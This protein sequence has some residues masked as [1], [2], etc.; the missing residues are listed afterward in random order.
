LCYDVLADTVNQAFWVSCD[1]GLFQWKI[2]DDSFQLISENISGSCAVQRFITSGRGGTALGIPGNRDC[3]DKA[4]VIQMIT[5]SVMTLTFPEA[6]VAP[7]QKVSQADISE[8]GNV[9]LLADLQSSALYKIDLT[10]GSW[11]TLA[12]AESAAAVALNYDGTRAW[13]LSRAMVYQVSFDSLRVVDSIPVSAGA[14][15]LWVSSFADNGALYDSDD[16]TF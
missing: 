3:G 7:L 12:I 2:G 1:D 13:Y 5:S 6:Q 4:I 15:S 14:A 11:Q 10:E 8:D 9:A 16:H